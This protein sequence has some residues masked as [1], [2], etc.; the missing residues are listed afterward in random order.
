MSH[1]LTSFCKQ[2][3]E[4]IDAIMN[5]DDGFHK[6][7]LEDKLALMA[8]HYFC[9]QL[10]MQNVWK[11]YQETTNGA[12][13]PKTIANITDE[14][15]K[16]R[17]AEMYHQTTSGTMVKGQKWSVEQCAQAAK[18]N[19]INFNDDLSAL[20]FYVALN[21]SWHDHYNSAFKL[22]KESEVKY[23]IYLA[24]DFLYD[25]DSGKTPNERVKKYYFN[26]M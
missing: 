26:L 8:S 24:E 14:I 5:Q 21:G 6:L 10:A 17:V 16:E 1:Q 3:H 9:N 23:Y 13:F 2:C 7:H 12:V 19:G 11:T 4:D 18:D 25:I 22:G 15:A 20:C